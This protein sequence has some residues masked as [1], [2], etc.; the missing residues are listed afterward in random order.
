MGQRI[1]ASISS[2]FKDVQDELAGKILGAV[3]D[4]THADAIGLIC[5]AYHS[6]SGG[7]PPT[8]LL[9]DALQSVDISRATSDQR[10]IVLKWRLQVAA[11]LG[12]YEVSAVAAEELLVGWGNTFTTEQICELRMIVAAAAAKRGSKETAHAIWRELLEDPESLGT[13]NR[14]WAWRNVSL[15][16]PIDDPEALQCARYSADAFLE[17]GDKTQ[18]AKSLMHVANCLQHC[19]PAKALSAIDE[20]LPLLDSEALTYRPVRAATLHA[21]A[22]RLMKLG[23]HSQAFD[24]AMGAVNTWRGIMGA[25]SELVRSMYLASFAA[26]SAGNQSA[27]ADLKSEADKLAAALGTPRFELGNRLLDLAGA[28]TSEAALQ[29]L[30]E[31][32]NSGDCDVVASVQYIR[33]EN[34]ATFSDN[35]RLMLLEET[36]NSLQKANS[37]S[38]IVQSLQCATGK[39]LVKMKQYKRAR[40][41]YERAIKAEPYDGHARAGVLNCLW[42]LEAWG[43][44]V[45]FLRSQISLFGELP[46]LMFYY[47]TAMY[48]AGDMSGAF[49]A[50]RRAEELTELNPV[51]RAEARALAEKAHA[52]AGTVTPMTPLPD[53]TLPVTL[54][55]LDEALDNFASFIA[56][57]KRMAF[58]TKPDTPI[59]SDYA[60]IKKPERLGQDLLHTFLK[61]RFQDRIDVFEELSAGAG[62]LDVYVKL[63]GGLSSIIELKMCGF[64][65]SSTY[66]ADGEDQIS[67]YM[68][69]RRS[70]I[71]YLVV[72]DARLEDFGSS[73]TD[74][75]RHDSLTIWTKFVD[76]RPRVTNKRAKKKC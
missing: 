52:K 57:S 40:V 46:G 75:K 69:S 14:G 54:E 23:Q 1:F 10:L 60:W 72:F 7:F 24:D 4:G 49:H 26:E 8:A 50:L 58:W 30:S 15:S 11:A 73:L 27:F 66:A 42:R 18:A 22:D 62:R 56:G 36:H 35:D 51:M 9:H 45:L 53:P 31:A 19:D 32:T 55:E 39:Q 67:H 61:A 38:K 37:R 16:L 41:W 43:D 70:S 47:G 2:K 3:A 59:K 29:L 28:F 64:H 63:Y 34:D 21:R 33:A 48:E 25:E 65:Y 12:K 71:G 68:G 13:I 20:I 5:D 6:E 74:T 17:A 44:A 76:L